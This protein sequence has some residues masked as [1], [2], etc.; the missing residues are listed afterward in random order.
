MRG[1]LFAFSHQNI[2]TSLFFPPGCADWLDIGEA[3][4]ATPLADDLDGDG[5]LE[6]LVATM[7]GGLYAVRMGAPFADPSAAAREAVPG[8]N[9]FVA[10]PG[11]QAIAADA[12]S[13]A[14]R[15]VRGRDLTVRFAV[16][17][18][19]PNGT[20]AAGGA[21]AAARGPY[22]VSVTL[23]GV[24]H[25]A[26]GAGPSPVVGMA[27]TVTAPGTYALTLPAPRTRSTALVV[28][29]MVDEVRERG[30]EEREREKKRGERERFR[31][32]LA[33]LPSKPHAPVSLSFPFFPLVRHPL[34]RLLCPVLPHPLPPPAQVRGGGAG[35]GGGGGGAGRSGRGGRRGQRRWARRLAGQGWVGRAAGELGRAA[36]VVRVAGGRVAGR[37]RACSRVCVRGRAHGADV[38]GG[39]G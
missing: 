25:A 35:P 2:S 13:R 1:F 30:R 23:S 39:L 16:V 24:G 22:R 17:D 38:R 21:Q 11:Y 29:E 31:A 33:P 4:Y 19:R 8:G 6:L 27:D 34:H 36:G 37:G 18:G 15:D 28:L 32:S 3:A 26:M 5:D 9:C 14:P 20:V 12:A 7:S 10:R